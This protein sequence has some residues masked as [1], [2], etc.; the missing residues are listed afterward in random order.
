MAL[1][2]AAGLHLAGPAAEVAE[3]AEVGEAGT[4]PEVRSQ[5]VTGWTW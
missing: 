4:D 3:V 1:S 2:P 5:V